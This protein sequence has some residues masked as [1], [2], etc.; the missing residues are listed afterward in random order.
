VLAN[1][2]YMVNSYDIPYSQADSATQKL[3]GVMVKNRHHITDPEYISPYYARTPVILYHLARLMAEFHIPELEVYREVLIRDA[4]DLYRKEP[5]FLDKL[6]LS[7][8]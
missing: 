6:I 3:I 2:L 4:I 8:A 7:T 5:E 1:V